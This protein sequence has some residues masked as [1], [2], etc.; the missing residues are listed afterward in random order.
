MAR[1]R[2]DLFPGRGWTR[3]IALIPLGLLAAVASGCFPAGLFGTGGNAPVPL[4]RERVLIVP[5]ATPQRSYFESEL[6]ARFSRDLAEVVR[7]SCPRAEVLDADNLPEGML[8]QKNPQLSVAELGKSLGADY[9]LVGEIHELRGKDPKSFRV[10][11]GTMVVVARVIDT[12][13]G[14]VIWQGN[15]REFH[16][17]P[18]LF[19]EPMP[20][21]ETEEEQV[22][23]K[24]MLEA[25]LGV[26]EV[27]TGPR[28]EERR[29][30]LPQ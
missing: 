28:K 22:V 10:L 15:R 6:G 30:L 9:V 25:A 11:R 16:Y 13:A 1:Q 29:S 12:Q 23:R 17:P 21:Q 7:Q 19:G 26:A 27:F 20:A 2:T 8:G 24:V 18:P 5:F 3:W 14:R 4:K